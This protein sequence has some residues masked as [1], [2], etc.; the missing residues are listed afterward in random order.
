MGLLDRIAA[1]A[2]VGTS[3]ARRGEARFGIDQWLTEFLLPA[4][5]F[6][7]NGNQYSAGAGYGLRTTMLGNRSTEVMQSLPGYMAALRSCPP[8]FGAQM[9]RA[10]VLS[11][12]R[13]T[14]R[15]RPWTKTPR[16]LFSTSAL[17]LLERPWP[18]AT[19]GE[20]V[21]RME[22][23]AGLAGNAYVLRQR[24]R[25]RVLR[26][27]WVA[28]LYGSDSEPDDAG[29]A[30][31]GQLIGYVYCNG[32][33]GS[34]NR[35]ETLMPDQV[36]HWSPIPNPE[37]AGV[38]ESWITP[39]IN[40][41]RGDVA[42]GQFQLQYWANSAT[43]NM[44]VSGIPATTREQFNE[45]VDT[46]EARHKGVANAFR[47]LYLTAGADAKPVGANL[48]DLDLRNSRGGNETRISLLSRVPAS[49]LG[50]A[51]GLAGSSLNAGNF[52]MARRI[53]ADSWVY[54][55]LQDLA[56]A[57]APIVRVPDDA[58]LWFDTA[59]MPLLREDAKDAAEIEQIKAT[60][61]TMYVREGFTADSAVAAVRGQDITLLT[62][63][64]MTSV[65]LQEPGAAPA[66]APAGEGDDAEEPLQRGRFRGERHLPGRHDQKSHGRRGP[67]KALKAGAGELAATVARLRGMSREDARDELDDMTRTQVGDVAEHLGMTGHSKARKRELVDRVLNR[68]GVSD[69]AVDADASGGAQ[70]DLSTSV[71]RQQAVIDSVRQVEAAPG[72]WVNIADIR[73]RLDEMGMPRAEQDEAI[74][75]LDRDPK[76]HVVPYANLKGLPQ[77]VHDGGV[78]MGGE[79]Q[80]RIA[81]A[82]GAAPWAGEA[83][84]ASGVAVAAAPSTLRRAQDRQR[85]IDRAR[86][87]STL[88]AK[89]LEALDH[90]D[91]IEV[92]REIASFHAEDLDA[93]DRH[94]AA[95]LLAALDDASNVD[96]P[97]VRQRLRQLEAAFG[98]ARVGEPGGRASYDRM[99]H[100][101]VGPHPEPGDPVE[102]VTPGHT[103]T[104]EGEEIVAT[105]ATVSAIRSDAATA[106]ADRIA[107]AVESGRVVSDDRIGGGK[108][109]DTRLQVFDDGTRVIRKRIPEFIDIQDELAKHNLGWADYPDPKHQ[110]DAEE[111][112][113]AVATALGLRAP[114]VH[115][116]GDGSVA[117]EFVEG[118][119]VAEQRAAG[120]DL[121]DFF[122]DFTLAETHDDGPL[123]GLLDLLVDNRDR[124][125]GNFLFDTDDRLVPI[126]HGFSFERAGAWDPGVIRDPAGASGFITP[127]FDEDGAWASNPLTQR[128]VGVARERLAA[129]RP[130]FEARGRADWHD[131]MMRRLDHIGGLASGDRDRIA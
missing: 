95:P 3:L 68:L 9:V 126:D 50:I 76:V 116:D 120:R 124:H 2:R 85:A 16:K 54:P 94:L 90:A 64:G 45:I 52:G 115:R 26:P 111:L 71:G 81:V 74:R 27:D 5:Q 106:A 53:F 39:A 118:T 40:D 13:F 127:F 130:Q 69:N 15:S 51:E 110:A 59:D 11:Q 28:I 48:D 107:R 49:L 102:I 83:P 67:R 121:P 34:G 14:F 113:P 128:D 82:P 72:S 41:I 98:L 6:G 31:D 24:D 29:H 108:I 62:H 20:L 63:T 66:P 23:H 38:G 44:I 21:A 125:D 104:H 4:V 35:F 56:A 57:L 103:L 33:F 88:A 91:D 42:A 18:N 8:A 19:T 105:R 46:L 17:G 60:T 84:G 114:A 80:H 92:A 7:W 25:L 131:L 100:E 97:D 32:G 78:V 93:A 65:Q 96:D 10:L 77:R 61:I 99:R 109:G 101:P 1:R 43:P 47:T 117:M 119:T 89:T 70:P 75:D 87:G 122:P 12:A 79:Q 123:I 22:W 86:A 129:L 30:I 73:D 55:T 36:A 112:V 37:S 58:E